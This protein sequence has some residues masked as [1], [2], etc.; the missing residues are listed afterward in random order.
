MTDNIVY[1]MAPPPG[2]SRDPEAPGHSTSLIAIVCTFLP[3]AGVAMVI[4]LYTR[5]RITRRVAID[6]YVMLVAFCFG[7]FLNI[8]A[9]LMLNYGLGKHLWNV[10]LEP[11]LNPDLVIRDILVSVAYFVAMGCAKCSILLLYLRIFTTTGIQRIIWAVLV[12]TAG[13]S[14]AAAA[15]TLFSCNPVTGA[16]IMK[17]TDHVR[18]IN[19]PAF[20]F[21]N[22]GLNITS[23]L[24]TVA[25]PIPKLFTLRMP[26][27]RKV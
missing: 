23:D 10:P 16:W 11:D 12:Y 14:F 25:I 17:A 13:F 20:Y 18:C 22:A 21:A 6:D 26:W 2:V 8:E 5:A 19:S 15:T 1:A 24:M 27:R 4:R 9:L 7:T 3:L